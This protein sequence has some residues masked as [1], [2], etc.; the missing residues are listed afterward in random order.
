MLMEGIMAEHSG[1]WSMEQVA[2]RVKG[3]MAVHGCVNWEN[4]GREVDEE[5][6]LLCAK[7]ATAL[8]GEMGT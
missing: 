7:E 5:A 6:R 3:E 4:I 8:L 2:E 1:V